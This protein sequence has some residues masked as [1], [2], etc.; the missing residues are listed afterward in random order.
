MVAWDPPSAAFRGLTVARL[1]SSGTIASS[2]SIS[3][4]S[5]GAISLT[6]V[7]ARV[8]ATWRDDDAVGIRV[9]EI[10]A[11]SRGVGS[12]VTVTAGGA[13]GLSQPAIGWNGTRVLVGWTQGS[14]PRHVRLAR[15]SSSLSSFD[16]LGGVGV[17]ATGAAH[18]FVRAAWG[19]SSWLIVWGERPGSDGNLYGARLRG[20][21][22]FTD[23]VGFTVSDTTDDEHSAV[24]ASTGTGVGWLVAYRAG[25]TL[26]MRI[27]SASGF[28]GSSTLLDSAGSTPY[29]GATADQYLVAWGFTYWRWIRFGTDG[30]R[31]D[32]ST[33]TSDLLDSL[34]S[35]AIVR[36]GTSFVLVWNH[37]GG[38][39]RSAR[40][41]SVLSPSTGSEIVSVTPSRGIDAESGGGTF[42]A[43]WTNTPT[44]SSS[45][46]VEASRFTPGVGAV[47]TRYVHRPG[48]TIQTPRI[49]YDG[50][51]FVTFF[52]REPDGG[53]L[54]WIE[55]FRTRP[56]GT[57][58]DPDGLRV[59]SG[60]GVSVQD[61]VAG[62]FRRILLL[63][64]GYDATAGARRTVGR[65]LDMASMGT[66]TLGTACTSA[67]ACASGHCVDG[68]CCDTSCGGDGSPCASCAASRGARAD[69]TCTT[70]SA[71]TTCRASRGVCDPA[72][73][74]DGVA[75]ACPA[76]ARTPAGTV[77][78][79]ATGPCELDATCTGT[80][81]SCPARTFVAAGT[82]CRD[83]AGT[84][85]VAEACDGAS[86]ACPPD[87]HVARGSECSPSLGDCDLA[88]ACDG[89]SAACPADT[90]RGSE[91]TC[92]TS[93]GPC[94]PA[95]RCDG[96]RPTCPTD[97]REAAGTVCGPADGECAAPSQCDGRG[98]QCNTV[99]VAA[100]TECRAA[101]DVCD[102]PE[103]CDGF[104]TTCPDDT[105]FP[106]GLRC[107]TDELYCNGI[108]R[109]S[110]G[111]CA[112]TSAPS[113]GPPELCSE[114]TRACLA[115][116]EEQPPSSGCAC[117]LAG[118]RRAPRPT[119]Q[120]A[121]VLLALARRRRASTLRG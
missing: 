74:C 11:D 70:M 99:P 5:I 83:V 35:A 117:T 2:G 110:A 3:G 79:A 118:S 95:E 49:V 109:C 81:S 59:H 105:S 30:T 8:L 45:S 25:T 43:A 24:V 32:A 54:E 75:A 91:T 7:D 17:T 15:L 62:D 65:I 64:I 61:A 90:R 42:I 38:G 57:A 10:G 50:T 114:E 46:S 96:S 33:R 112:P 94:D 103:R 92:R 26:R 44:G 39:V 12:P 6:S 52:D 1:G 28:A 63:Y 66:A 68:V 111:R 86:P 41:S 89:T 100:G 93:G 18:T 36:D 37:R 76:D 98:T 104:H 9:Q 53:G 40:V 55:M 56:D 102:L 22:T 101:S 116:P 119:L 97:R 16:P 72:E 88:E 85:D 115:P 77:C 47:G 29:V 27:V 73:A 87:E 34:S 14:S 69:G 48:R 106:N 78:G 120:L 13:T 71:G 67:F 4:S 113:C 107:D 60:G 58:L 23:T 51:D 121:L 19:G 108:M 31:V 20:D 80:S 84:C 82:V 21:G